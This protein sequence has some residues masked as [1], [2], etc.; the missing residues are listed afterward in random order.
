MC[1]PLKHAKENLLEKGEHLGF[2][3]EIVHN[4]MGIRCGYIRVTPGHP[5]FEKDYAEIDASCHGGFTF[6]RHGTACPTHGPE[7]EW[8]LGFD[9]GHGG[10]GMDFTL[11]GRHREARERVP[12]FGVFSSPYDLMGDEVRSTEFVKAQ[13]L[14]LCEQA[15]AAA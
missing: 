7:A 13:C 3:W 11:P 1:L 15:A 4:G 2:E 10:D 5:W 12:S 9:C 14:S 8:W 6:A